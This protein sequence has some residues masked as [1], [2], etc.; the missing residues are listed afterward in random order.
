MP[1]KSVKKKSRLGPGRLSAEAAAELPDRLLDAA[2]ALFESQGFADTSMEEIA[3]G[4]GASTKT[5]YARYA[6]KVA[7]LEAVARRMV[8]RNLAQHAASPVGD[9]TKVDPR[10]FLV[11]LG[12]R[13]LSKISGE[14]APLIRF[15]LSD[16]CRVPQLAEKYRATV[17]LAEA[18]FTNALTIWRQQGLLPKLDDPARAASLALSMLTDPGRIRTALGD[19]MTKAEIDAHASYAADMFLRACGYKAARA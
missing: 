3:R 1:K 15:A 5:L 16:G 6:D 10:T 7:V 12:T 13:A 4:A 8:E 9:P 18:A 14:G 2:L 17:A 19:P 11:A